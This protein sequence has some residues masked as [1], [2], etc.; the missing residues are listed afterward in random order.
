MTGYCF[1]GVAGIALTLAFV[2]PAMADTGG[3]MGMWAR[4]DGVARVRVAPC[5]SNI[6]ATNTWIKPGITDEKAGDV[7]VMTIKPESSN[8]YR[9]SAYD[10]KR[11]ISFRMKLDVNGNSMT[12]R[13][14]VLGGIVCKSVNWS[15]IN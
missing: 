8:S 1:A 12:T 10:P 9:G 5:G 6:C 15:R 14:C 11:N 2:G 7:L 4:G 3:P 13:G